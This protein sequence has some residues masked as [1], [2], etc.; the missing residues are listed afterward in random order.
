MT[1][2]ACAN[3]PDRLAMGYCSGCGKALCAGCIVRLS[4][5]NYCQ[6]CAETPDHRPPQ[7]RAGRSRVWL[8]IG[9]AGLITIGFLLSRML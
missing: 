3:H 8:W 6:V 7:P 2:I 9:L 4:D 5:G 1:G